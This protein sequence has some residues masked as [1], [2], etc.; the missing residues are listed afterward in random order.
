VEVIPMPR[1]KPTRTDTQPGNTAQHASST[2]GELAVEVI[3][4]FQRKKN[5]GT[6]RPSNKAQ[7]VDSN[8]DDCISRVYN[9]AEPTKALPI[10]SNEARHYVFLLS[11]EDGNEAGRFV[12]ITMDTAFLRLS[13]QVKGPNAQFLRD[14]PLVEVSDK[15]FNHVYP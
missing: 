6:Q 1:R 2:P 13:T 9:S 8:D 12:T 15:T 5:E 7:L 4:M 11:L 10:G 14:N 3:P